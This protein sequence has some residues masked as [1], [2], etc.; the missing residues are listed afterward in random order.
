[1]LRVMRHRQDVEDGLTPRGIVDSVREVVKIRLPHISVH[2]R[3]HLGAG[4]SLPKNPLQLLLEAQI[5][6]RS[7]GRIPLLR[8]KDILSSLPAEAYPWPTRGW[9][10][11]QL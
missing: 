4:F 6:T 10:R 2:D 11:F 7:T 5:E 9:A 8:S 3:E 1:M